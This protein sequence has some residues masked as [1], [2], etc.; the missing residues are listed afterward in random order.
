MLLI[1]I[2]SVVGLFFIGNTAKQ[3]GA[4]IALGIDKSS[5]LGQ[6]FD[7]TVSLV[8]GLGCLSTVEVLIWNTSH[9]QLIQP[10]LLLATIA[11]YMIIRNYF[12]KGEDPY[13]VRIF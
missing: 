8:L 2:L 12:T 9:R 6:R 3:G 13:G 10:V 11:C 7:T 5:G 1:I 4:S